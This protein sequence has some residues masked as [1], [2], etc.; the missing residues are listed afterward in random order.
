MFFTLK[1]EIKKR[2]HIM[3]LIE[4]LGFSLITFSGILFELYELIMIN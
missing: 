4:I 1:V 2:E 3:S